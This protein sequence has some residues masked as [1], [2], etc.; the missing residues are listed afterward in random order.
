M[1]QII[2]LTKINTKEIGLGGKV[3][4]MQEKT[5]DD[6]LTHYL[7]AE[8]KRIIILVSHSTILLAIFFLSRK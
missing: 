2:S 1:K 7:Q 3:K 6:I 5:M 4:Q 8:Y